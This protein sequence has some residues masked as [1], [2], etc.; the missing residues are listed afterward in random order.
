MDSTSDTK[1]IQTDC[2]IAG[3]GPAGIM[4]GFLLVRAGVDVTILEKWP[5]FF[6]DFRGDTIHPSTMDILNELGLLDEFL[7]L[8]HQEIPRVVAAIGDQEITIADFEHLHVRCPFLGFM[9]Q[10]DF[11]NFIAEYGR[12]FSNFHLLM[13]TE[14]LDLIYE[15]GKATGLTARNSSGTFDIRAKLVVGADGR[16]SVVREK[17]HLP[18]QSLGAPMD[19]LWF[20]IS[21]KKSDPVPVL[22]RLER[23]EM[24][25]MI[26]RDDYWQCGF[27]IPKGNFEQTKQQGLGSLHTR[28]LDLAPFL[29]SRSQEISDWSQVKLLSV[30][31]E[32][33][34]QWYQDGLIC[35][36]D[37]AH[38]MSPIG[39]VG[40]NLAIQDAV[41]AANILIPAFRRGGPKLSDLQAIQKR[42]QLPTKII[43]RMQIYIQNHLIYHVVA[44]DLKLQVPW[45]L[46][47]LSRFPALRRIPARMIG[48]GFRPEHVTQK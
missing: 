32:R 33:L 38:A 9:P 6:R 12:K 1:N 7:K 13:E 23:G 20:R 25:I 36:G 14:A 18:N 30:A 3:G 34:S 45:F 46:K 35:I 21:R 43:Q 40:I 27:I 17:S 44:G 31:V 10:W 5:D 42:R 24:M 4:L 41:A 19:V 2:C 47:L 15:N 28:I 16:H 11:L 29:E 39:G 8:P 22:G 26:D 48:V 37:A